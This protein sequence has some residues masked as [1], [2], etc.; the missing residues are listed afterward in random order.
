MDSIRQ[1][2][3][4]IIETAIAEVKLREIIFPKSH[5][6]PNENAYAHPC[7]RLIFLLSGNFWMKAAI[8]GEITEQIY[9]PGQCIFSAPYCWTQNLFRLK[10]SYFSVVFFP[11]YIRMLMLDS[12]LNSQVPM[13]TYH[14]HSAI[15]S[16]GRYLINALCESAAGAANKLADKQ[17][18]LIL[19]ALLLEV[20]MHIKSSPA[21]TLESKSLHVFRKIT[22]YIIEN[23]YN[24]EFSRQHICREFCLSTGHISRLFKQFSHES[25][26]QFLVRIRLEKSLHFLTCSNLTISEIADKC[27]YCNVSYFIKAFKQCYNISPGRFRSKSSF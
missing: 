25:Y 18:V 20:V 15:N 27:G 5:P 3:I 2:F 12:E 1:Q 21:A 7:P 13:I 23:S 24:A 22:D 6:L 14:T 19:R 16:K 17:A 11:N 9:K 26:S 10:Y 4:E 8:G